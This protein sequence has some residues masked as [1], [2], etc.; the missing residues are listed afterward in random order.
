[1][2]APPEHEDCRPFVHVAGLLRAAGVNAPEV[3]AQDLEQGFLLLTDLGTTTYLQAPRRRQLPTR[4]SRDAIGA[5][6][7]WQL[8][9]ARRA[10]ALRRSAAAPRTRLFSRL[11]PRPPPRPA[12]LSAR[13][14]ARRWSAC[15]RRSSRT[16]SPQPQ[17]YVHRDYMPRNLMV[18][19]PNP[20]VLDFQDAVYRP[21]QLRRGF[22]LARRLHQLGGRA[23]ARLGAC[24]TGRAP[25]KPACRCAPISPIST[26]TSNGWACSATSRC[27]ASSRASTTA[28]ARRTT[29]PTR[30]AFWL[31][32]RTPRTR[33]RELAPL[34][35]LLDQFEGRVAERV[36]SF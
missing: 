6:S 34:A 32:A 31:R 30:R 18:C 17:V 26:A 11:V 7:R 5:L 20:G 22:A 12:Y 8:A 21:D 2:D 28:T 35:H 25:A 36:Y 24:A 10:A 16:I 27:W 13:S 9:S 33:Y 19:E 29:S 14:S 23:R 15:S 4:C 1:M 3:L